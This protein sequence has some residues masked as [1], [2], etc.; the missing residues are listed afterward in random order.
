MSVFVFGEEEDDLLSEASRNNGFLSY[1]HVARHYGDE[2]VSHVLLQ[3]HGK[4]V[5]TVSTT[6]A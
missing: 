1:E 2:K 3:V 5:P 6:L 4:I